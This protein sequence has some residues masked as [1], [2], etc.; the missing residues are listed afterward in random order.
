ML[1]MPDAVSEGSSQSNFPT[2]CRPV[3]S[4]CFANQLGAGRLSWCALLLA[5][6]LLLTCG[7]ADPADVNE[8]L[9]DFS[10]GRFAEA[11]AAWQAAA[12]A[13]DPDG[14]LYMGVLYDTGEGVEQDYAKALAFYKRAADAGS[15]AGAF[16]VGVFYDSGIGVTT[17]RHQAAAWYRKAAAKG[18]ARA[19]YNLALLEEDG[20]GVPRNRARAIALFRQ[21]AAQGLNAARSHLAALGQHDTQPSVRPKDDAMADFQRAQDTLLNRGAAEAA[22]IAT[23]FRRAADRHNAVAEYDLGYCYEHGVGVVADRAQARSWYERAL[24]DTQ[25][26]HLHEIAQESASKL[27][28]Q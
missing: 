20:T 23:L 7:A 11:F 18:F 5:A 28:R 16:N 2:V 13:G 3:P 17:D 1:Y 27:E 12:Q 9:V 24:A 8:G 26:S 15:A 21:A 6:A 14:D 25:D 19:E 22:R 4:R 10:A